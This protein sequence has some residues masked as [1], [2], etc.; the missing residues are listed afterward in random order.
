MFI[1]I[2][3]LE[4]CVITIECYQLFN[5]VWEFTVFSQA[6]SFVMVV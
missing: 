1:K 3:H 5:H 4:C 2:V 6:L